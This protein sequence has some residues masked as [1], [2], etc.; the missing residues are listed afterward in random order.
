[1][2]T[3]QERFQKNKTEILRHAASA[4]I[5]AAFFTSICIFDLNAITMVS[6]TGLL[7]T[8][9]GVVYGHVGKGDGKG[10]RFVKDEYFIEL[11]ENLYKFINK[12]LQAL[13]TAALLVNPAFTAGF[14][15]TIFFVWKLANCL[16]DFYSLWFLTMSYPCYQIADLMFHDEIEA[17]KAKV[18]AMVH[19]QLAGLSQKLPKAEGGAKTD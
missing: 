8:V 16:G 4:G 11:Y 1:M 6:V 5:V 9:A 14:I 19:Q 2:S 13:R 15:A 3:P 18:S 12:F 7:G 10:L 17:L